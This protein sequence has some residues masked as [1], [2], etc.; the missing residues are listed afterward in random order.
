MVEFYY[1]VLKQ[2]S[3]KQS[4]IH[5]IMQTKSL[6]G[7]GGEEKKNYPLNH[8]LVFFTLYHLHFYDANN[9]KSSLHTTYHCCIHNE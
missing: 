8:V 3:K 2:N 6:T 5:G 7:S 1:W 4:R 9:N